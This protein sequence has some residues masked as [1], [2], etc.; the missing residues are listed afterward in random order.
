MIGITFVGSKVIFC[1][2]RK[3]RKVV[4]RWL[5]KTDIPLY[6]PNGQLPKFEQEEVEALVGSYLSGKTERNQVIESQIR[7]TLTIASMYV[8]RFP[9]KS[10]ELVSDALL[11]LVK[12]VNRYPKIATTNNISAYVHK[13]VWN[14]LKQAILKNRLI[15]I[16][17]TTINRK[18]LT[19]IDVIDIVDRG[20]TPVN[21]VD[22]KDFLNVVFKSDED[23]KILKM[24]VARYT[25]K[26]IADE[27]RVKVSYVW[28]KCS[29]I[30]Q[31]L[32]LHLP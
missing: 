1:D 19:N 28:S 26:E 4:S 29:E 25:G 18:K 6:F 27:L 22:E 20:Y 31:K 8:S 7:L 21:K 5:I 23:R 10:D 12:A 32:E 3:S 14:D 11:S 30:R 15:P 24:R 17:S 2:P 9:N 13:T 16:P